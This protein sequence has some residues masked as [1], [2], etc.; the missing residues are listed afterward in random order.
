MAT[1][2][3]P[4]S[5]KSSFYSKLDATLESFEFDAKVRSL[6][7]PAYTQTGTGRPGIDLVVYLQTGS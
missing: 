2:Q 3:L 1:Q 4:T 5:P 7:A 6:C